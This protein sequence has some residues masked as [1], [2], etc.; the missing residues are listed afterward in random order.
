MK[1]NHQRGLY[2]GHV[3]M[4]VN[5]YMEQSKLQGLHKCQNQ[6]TNTT[7]VNCEYNLNLRQILIHWTEFF[8][9][10]IRPLI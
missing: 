5:C 10:F 2:S 8:M 7:K 6:V 4:T 9:W 3:Y 1:V